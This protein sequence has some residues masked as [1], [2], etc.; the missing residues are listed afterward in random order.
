MPKILQMKSGRDLG[1]GDCFI[2]LP[3]KKLKHLIQGRFL[4]VCLVCLPAFVAIHLSIV[5]LSISFTVRRRL[6]S[7]LVHDKAPEETLLGND[8]AIGVVR[9]LPRPGVTQEETP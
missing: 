3:R 6:P 9:S 5:F 4:P 2:C 1:S 8:E 7:S